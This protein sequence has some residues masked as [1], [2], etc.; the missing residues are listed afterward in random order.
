MGVQG[1]KDWDAKH[2]VCLQEYFLSTY[3][4]PGTRDS[5]VNNTGATPVLMELTPCR[6][7][8]QMLSEYITWETSDEGE[9]ET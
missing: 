9:A 7:E 3:C 8:G 2:E 5:T 1:G 6:A 4:A